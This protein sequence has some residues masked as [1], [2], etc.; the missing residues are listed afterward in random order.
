MVPGMTDGNMGT[1]FDCLLGRPAAAA[2]DVV[3]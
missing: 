2:P 3:R 1:S